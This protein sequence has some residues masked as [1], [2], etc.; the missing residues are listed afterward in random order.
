MGEVAARAEEVDELGVVCVCGDADESGD[1]EEMEEGGSASHGRCRVSAEHGETR[2]PRSRERLAIQRCDCARQPAGAGEV[3][4]SHLT[5]PPDVWWRPLLPTSSAI[6]SCHLVLRGLAGGG[7]AGWGRGPREWS[8][9][10]SCNY[11]SN[12]RVRM[13]RRRLAFGR[14]VVFLAGAA[15]TAL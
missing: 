12:L 13:S 11:S 15:E 9:P 3:A 5:V 2:V 10:L 8:T 6:S 4:E 14:V 7:S 1:D